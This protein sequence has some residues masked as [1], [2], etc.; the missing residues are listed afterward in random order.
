MPGE[1]FILIGFGG[2][3]GRVRAIGPDRIPTAPAGTFVLV[4]TRARR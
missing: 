3:G 1:I 2:Y 4:Y